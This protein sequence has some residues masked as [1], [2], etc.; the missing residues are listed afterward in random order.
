MICSARMLLAVL[1]SIVTRNSTI[2]DKLCSS[3]TV[4]VPWANDAPC[5][6]DSM[7][8]ALNCGREANVPA[9]AEQYAAEGR[10]RTLAFTAVEEDVA[11][12]VVEGGAAVDV[13]AVVVS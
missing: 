6:V 11:V 12:D 13:V 8:A 7:S 5:S 4:I 2:N 10:T 9:Q 1:D 3:L